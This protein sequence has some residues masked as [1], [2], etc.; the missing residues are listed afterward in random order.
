M[1]SDVWADSAYRSDEIEQK[2]AE[3]GLK[4]RIH[5]RAY[6]NRKLSEA[7]TAANTP[8]SKVRARW[9]ARVRFP[10]RSFDHHTC[11]TASSAR[12]AKLE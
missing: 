10:C 2:L 5:R 1:A 8:R 9:C 6:G 3:R 4:S 7:Q 11:S 12:G